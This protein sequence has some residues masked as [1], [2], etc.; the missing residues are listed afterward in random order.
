MNSM[1][2]PALSH[3][4]ILLGTTPPPFI[5]IHAVYASYALKLISSAL[6]PSSV[7]DQKDDTPA[8]AILDCVECFSPQIVYSRVLCDLR[9]ALDLGVDDNGSA[10]AGWDAFV[11]ALRRVYFDAE[12]L[13]QDGVALSRNLVLL[14]THADRL[15]DNLPALVVPLTRL[16]ELVSMI[17]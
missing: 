17:L 14:F 16:A 8:L 1:T 9:A 13:K 4:G 12:R 5:Y 2:P 7:S 15:R 11:D 10:G 6:L 3:L